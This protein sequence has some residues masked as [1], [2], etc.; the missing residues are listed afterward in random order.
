MRVD[1][2]RWIWRI[3]ERDRLMHWA[4][5]IQ[6]DKHLFIENFKS[7]YLPRGTLLTIFTKTHIE[8]WDICF[9]CFLFLFCFFFFFFQIAIQNQIGTVPRIYN[10]SSKNRSYNETIFKKYHM[11]MLWV[12]KVQ[13][14]KPFL[15][16]FFFWISSFQV[17]KCVSFCICTLN[18]NFT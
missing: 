13:A 3:H 18:F 6:I 11:D 17:I 7:R 14:A 1:R 9:L 10:T 12:I 15:L 5:K 4:V 2:I 8:A 16:F